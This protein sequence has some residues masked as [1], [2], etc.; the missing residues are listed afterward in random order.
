MIDFCKLRTVLHKQGGN[1][2]SIC[3]RFISDENYKKKL[4]QAFNF[5]MSSS[6]QED[7]IG[8]FVELVSDDT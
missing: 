8:E 4:F 1:S 2:D 5:L 7:T 3:L 6:E